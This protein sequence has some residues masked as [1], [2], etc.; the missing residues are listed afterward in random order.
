M[1]RVVQRQGG[2]QVSGKALNAAWRE[3]LELGR[4]L[5]ILNQSSRPYI[6]DLADKS[7]APDLKPILDQRELI[8][9]VAAELSGGEADLWLPNWLGREIGY[10]HRM[11][12]GHLQ[13]V[14]EAN[15]TFTDAPSLPI[16]RQALKTRRVCRGRPAGEKAVL[17]I[18][19]L[20]PSREDESLVLGV[21]TIQRS[22]GPSFR[23]AEREVL[24]GLA[25]QAAIAVQNSRQMAVERWRVEQLSLVREVSMQLLGDLGDLDVLVGHV[26]HLILETFEYYYV[27]IFTLDPGQESLCFRASAGPVDSVVQKDYPKSDSQIFVRL[28]E[29]IIG[30]VAQ[31]GQEI[32]A[33]DVNQESQYRYLE[34]LPET[35]SE[36]ALP[37]K[38]NQRVIGVLDVQSNLAQDFHEIDVLVLRALAG[39]IALAFEGAQLYENLRQ[40]VEQLSTIYQV[41]NAVTSILVEEEMLQ[42]VADLIQEH[43]GYPFVHL[44]SVH[45]GRRKVFFEAGSGQ[46]SRALAEQK[47]AYNLDDQS[48]IIPWVARH[49]EPVLANDVSL[50]ERYRPAPMLAEQ[51]QA[52]LAVPLMFADTVLGVLDIQSDRSGAFDQEA[53]FLFETLADSIAIAL[54][55]ASLYHSERWRRQ[56]ADSISQVA[57]ML[58]AEV[59]LDQVL[60]AILEELERN[61][62]CDLAAIWF[63][64]EN[65]GVDRQPEDLPILRLAAL[66]SGEVAWLEQQIGLDLDEIIEFKGPGEPDSSPDWIYAGLKSEQPVTRPGDALQDLFGQ[67]LDLPAN[68]SAIASALRVG[69]KVL[70]LLT[71]VHRTNS[72]Y[73]SEARAMTATFASYASVAIQNTRLYESAHEQVWVSTVLL[74]VA[75]AA[76]SLGDLDE[77]LSTVVNI[78]PMLVGVKACAIYLANPDGIFYP[79]VAAGL[80]PE[81]YEEFERHRYKPGDVPAL[82][83]LWQDKHPTILQRQGDDLRLSSLVTPVQ[84]QNHSLELLVLVPLLAHGDVLGAMLV[85]YSS[86]PFTNAVQAIDNFMEE[87]LSILQGIAHQTAATV[88]NTHLLRSQ[89]EEAYVS[90]ALLQ[91]AQAI[92]SSNDLQEMLSAIVRITPILIGVKRVAIYL[93]EKNSSQLQLTQ[94]YGLPR[95]VDTSP[96]AID[97]FPLIEAALERDALAAYPL[98]PKMDEQWED[99][100]EIWTYLPAPDQEEVDEYLASEN[101]L[102][103]VFPLSVQGEV[104]GA[105]L[106]EEPDTHP[107]E[108]SASSVS[109]LRLRSKRL[110]ITTGISQQAALAVQNDQLKGEMVERERLE[111]EMQ[112]ARQI[113]R[114]FLPQ[115][116]PR[117]PGWEINV[118]WRTA[119]EVGGDFYDLFSLPGNRLGLVIADVSDKGMSAALFM[120]LVRA[121]LHA[122]IKDTTSP[123]EVMERVNELLVPDAVGG[124]FVTLIYAVLDLQN[125]RITY[126]NAGHNPPIWVRKQTAEFE[127]LTRTSM[128]LGVMENIEIEERSVMIE[129][130]DFLVLYT[131]G[132]TDVFSP[133]DIPFGSERLQQCVWDAAFCEPE[134]EASAQ[135]MLEAIDS[136]VD[137]FAGGVPPMDDS[138]ALIFYRQ[139]DRKQG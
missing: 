118:W 59:N 33:E 9:A 39:N 99:A 66:R 30:A 94:S 32:L 96:F 15:A 58:S 89:K 119:R 49:G 19:L 130:G 48:G 135:G 68:Y 62:P 77:L 47:F 64:E 28:G 104:M 134:H 81:S 3:I 133:E 111:R 79:A 112:L 108:D 95:Q 42:V 125:G 55:N 92:V 4:Q 31:N 69:N 36:F 101:P 54:R 21:L 70:G 60:A 11:I 128:A 29:G 87:R 51:T 44:F 83:H 71:L 17:A 72:R 139:N 53:L 82:D 41:G 116:M 43:F 102:L 90:V 123:A 98:N 86:D 40:R 97:E 109:N 129:P 50:D 137:A 132:V 122:S 20:A 7:F 78:T 45:P 65:Q 63:L 52:E 105:L 74:Q 107:D 88:E 2:N 18:P 6:R 35:Q 110:E 127:L 24:E 61:L 46:R 14:L 8:V 16:A 124:T 121:L 126:A 37:L 85:Q 57:G 38:V 80:S 103:M 56:V 100:P 120:V 91:V 12:P 67:A 106:V 34:T 84:S 23:K 75:E 13:E 76:Q 115:E 10:Q 5:Q 93:L 22:D 26:A 117:L 25:A 136:A 114:T 1:S 131:D 73:G 113:Q 138:T 27:A